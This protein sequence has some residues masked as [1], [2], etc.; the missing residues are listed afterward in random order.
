MLIVLKT[1][2]AI[3]CSI[4]RSRAAPK[5]ENV[6]L[7]HQIGV[8]HRSASNASIL[9]LSIAS[10]RKEHSSCPANQGEITR[11]EQCGEDGILVERL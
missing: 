9:R 10:G 2:L 1:L 5:L 3:V 11:S 6:A 4:V 8:P 7:H